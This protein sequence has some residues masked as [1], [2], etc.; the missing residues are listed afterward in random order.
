MLRAMRRRGVDP[1]H[2]AYDPAAVGPDGLPFCRRCLTQLQPGQRGFCSAA[3]R[4]ETLIRLSPSYARAAVHARDRGICYHCRMDCGLL[5]RT[6]RWVMTDEEDGEEIALRTLEALGFGR[7]K[8]MLS[9][10]QM[11]HRQAV[12]EGGADCGL[13]NYRTLCLACHARAT[14]DL[15]RRLH[16]ARVCP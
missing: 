2:P 12:A 4:H 3:C 5:D 13:G 14:R 16:D 6:L 8:R 1:D 15:H 11:D 9:T 10:W 7:R